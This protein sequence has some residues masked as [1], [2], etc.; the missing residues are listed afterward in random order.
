[1][2]ECF[3]VESLQKR[4]YQSHIHLISTYYLQTIDMS[5]I[6]LQT[7]GIPSRTKVLSLYCEFNKYYYYSNADATATP[8]EVLSL[9]QLTDWSGFYLAF[10]FFKNCVIVHG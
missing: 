10:L 1:M 7:A 4:E 8:S 9:S 3:V 2:Y 5:S 6:A